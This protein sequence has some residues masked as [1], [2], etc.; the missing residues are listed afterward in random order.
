M[1][2]YVKL[3]DI[4]AYRLA[5]ELSDMGWEMYEPLHWKDK[6]IMGDQFIEAV[7]SHGANIAEGYGRYHYL[8][9]IKFYYNARASLFESKHWA[10]RLYIRKKI[11][12]EQWTQF[13]QK[14][15]HCNI[16]LNQF[17]AS[18]YATKKDGQISKD[19]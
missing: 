4:K 10:Y 17:I 6:K 5:I 13:L 8:D 11:S 12:R 2:Q 3:G 15:D 16:V 7:D 9:R 1:A 18:S 19:S 14:A